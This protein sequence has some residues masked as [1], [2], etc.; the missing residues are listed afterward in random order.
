MHDV[1]TGAM[2]WRW[3][4]DDAILCCSVLAGGHIAVGGDSGY[5]AVV[6]PPP[7]V[8]DQIAPVYTKPVNV[9]ATPSASL[10]LTA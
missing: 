2:L 6:S 3:K 1:S 4:A 5:A 8:A 7:D 10:P 9:F